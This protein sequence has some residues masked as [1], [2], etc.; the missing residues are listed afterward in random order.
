MT[1][2]PPDSTTPA[3]DLLRGI[4]AGGPD[5]IPHRALFENGLPA[6]VVSRLVEALRSRGYVR[7]EPLTGC[8]VAT[9]DGLRRLA[10]TSLPRS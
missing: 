3:L 4:A 5:G 1:I 10:G 8:W 6:H 9:A 7:F 2:H